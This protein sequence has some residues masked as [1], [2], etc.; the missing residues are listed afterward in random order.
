[1]P[2]APERSFTPG[3][4]SDCLRELGGL[5]AMRRR[6]IHPELAMC[7][8]RKVIGTAHVDAALSAR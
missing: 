1:M 3:T 4:M 2:S 7:G 5:G 6:P 8:D